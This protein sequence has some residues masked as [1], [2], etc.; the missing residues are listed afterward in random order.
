MKALVERD[1]EQEV[2]G[3]ALGVVDAAIA[4]VKEAKPDDPVVLATAELLSADMIA[5]GDGVRAADILVVAD[6]LSAAIGPK[7]IV[8]A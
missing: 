6:Q 8:I 3:I 5:S 1:P 4:A 7:P 2:R